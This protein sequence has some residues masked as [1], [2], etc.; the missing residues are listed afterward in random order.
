MENDVNRL[1]EKEYWNKVLSDAKLP[2]CNRE[3][4][5]GYSITMKFIHQ[6]LKNNS[7]STFLEVGC[8]SSGWLPYFSKKYDYH[9]SGLD[10]SEIGCKLCEENLKMQNIEYGD[11]FCSD[12]FDDNCTQGRNYDIIFTYGVIE[13][14]DEPEEVIKKLTKHLNS[15]GII[16]TLVP[17]L[18]GMMGLLS[19]IFVPDIYHMHKV[20]TKKKLLK[21]HISSNLQNVKTNY[22]GIFLLGV[23]PWIRSKNWLFREGSFQ[24]KISFRVLNL[25]NHILN[26]IF[27][28]IPSNLGASRMFSPYVISICKKV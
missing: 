17:N 18:N 5:Y 23:I 15:S 21:Y 24:S 25:L 12:L 6:V 4:E 13:H 7:F 10:Y 19:K 27:I 28:R 9:I 11:I 16:I 2:R 3:D 8:G 14:F 26:Y 22:A 20:I 1:T